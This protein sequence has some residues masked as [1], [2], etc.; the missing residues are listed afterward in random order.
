MAN[1]V[2]ESL[3]KYK[4]LERLGRGG[5][6]EVYKAHHPKLGRTVAIKILHGYLAEG[7]DFLGRFER[8]A[9]AVATLRHPHIVQIHDFDVDNATYYMVMEYI[10]GGTLQDR[11]ADLRRTGKYMPLGQV[12]AILK[13]IAEALDYAHRKGI[14]HRDIKPSNILLNDSGEAFLADFGIAR[15]VSNTQFTSTGAL[16]GTP[17]YMSPEQG[18]GQELTSASDVYSLG[19]I[20][21][22]LL[23][24]QAPYAADTPLAVIQ[25]HISEPLPPPGSL[26]PALPASLE[27]VVA[28]ALAKEPG[29]RYQSA[30]NLAHALSEALT[31]DL[32][33][34]L[35]QG[36]TKKTKKELAPQ[37][38][39]KMS[40]ASLPG[41]QRLPTVTMSEEERA[42]IGI[43]PPAAPSAES[44][45]EEP[46]IPVGEPKPGTAN[47]GSRRAAK[48][49]RTHGSSWKE[50][51]RSKPLL[52]GIIGLVIVVV[53]IIVFTSLPKNTECQSV[54][55]CI[56]LAEELNRQGNPEGAIAAYGRAG[57]MVPLQEHQQNAGIW[58]TRADLLELIG[59]HDEARMNRDM[60]AIWK[61]GE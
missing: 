38:T 55:A 23:T 8:E 19:V 24:G 52:F 35:D 7:E 33:A 15:M 53:L 61:R 1:L 21:Y 2:G 4:L 5:M 44:V 32:I 25:M 50:R 11:M 34:E 54:H 36:V 13:Q 31:P 60:C 6:A 12:L 28:K 20:L 10:D 59:R 39:E 14:I 17:T 9:R 18:R 3:G 40:D 48:S 46:S 56:A 26:R 49:G 58:C 27:T 29:S 51:L 57:E 47:G 16:I 45:P 43:K 42:G 41:R 37:P 30:G 22:E